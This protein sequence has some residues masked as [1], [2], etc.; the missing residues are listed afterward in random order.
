[1][2]SVTVNLSG[3]EGPAAGAMFDD[4]TNG[5]QIAGDGVW[6]LDYT[7]RAGN[8]INLVRNVTVTASRQRR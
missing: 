3:F 5:D 4:G 8:L 1:M 2:T 7:V 6:T